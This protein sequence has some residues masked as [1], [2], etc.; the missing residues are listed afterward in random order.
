MRGRE[1]GGGRGLGTM[2]RLIFKRAPIGSNQDD[3]D[4]LAHQTIAPAPTNITKLV[5][6]Y[7]A[8]LPNSH[9]R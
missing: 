5:M 9:A 8:K 6:V 2:T 3:F 7:T 4:V 1:A